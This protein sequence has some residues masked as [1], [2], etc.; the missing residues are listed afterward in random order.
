MKPRSLLPVAL[1]LLL[2]PLAAAQVPPDRALA[3][4]KVADGL[5]LDLFA[6]K[7]L[8]VTPTSRDVAQRGG[9]GVW[10]GVNSRR[11]LRG[12]PPLRQEGDR[13]VILEDTRGVGK[14]D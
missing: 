11:K 3:T 2:P 7:P 1:L 4:M 10:G 6:A 9:V 13:I 14:A 12:Q 8:F 5:Q